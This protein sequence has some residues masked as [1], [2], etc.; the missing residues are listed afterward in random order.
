MTTDVSATA[1]VMRRSGTSSLA[2]AENF[3]FAG[4][5]PCAAPS[6]ATH[7]ASLLRA[8]AHPAAVAIVNVPFPPS[9]SKLSGLAV[10]VNAHA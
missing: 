10:T 9:R 6:T 2:C 8:H 3:T 7:V 5:S 4:P 1:S